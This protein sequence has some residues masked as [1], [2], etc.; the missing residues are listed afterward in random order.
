MDKII[1][2]FIENSKGFWPRTGHEVGRRAVVGLAVDDRSVV[3]SLAMTLA[4]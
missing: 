3:L 4:K 1:R 2:D